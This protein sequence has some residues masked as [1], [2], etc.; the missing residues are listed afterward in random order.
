[1]Y[2]AEG[3]LHDSDSIIVKDGGHVFRWEFVGCVA[4][5]KTCFAHGTVTDD[6]ASER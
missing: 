2:P 4:D 6:Y 5:Q 1:M 3:C